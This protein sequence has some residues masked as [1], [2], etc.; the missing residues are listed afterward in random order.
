MADFKKPV[1]IV[2]AG[3]NGSGK[4]SITSKI[5]KH[6]WV[7]GCTYINPDN[8]AQNVYGDWN[9]PESVLKAVIYAE[10][11]RKKCI[12]ENKSL[13]FE[14]VFSSQEKIEFLQNAKSNGFFIRFFFVGTDHPSINAGR[15]A[16]RVMQGGHDVPISKIISRYSKSIVN[17]AAI[18]KV[19]DR[20]YIYDNSIEF[21]EPKL[22]F[23]CTTGKLLKSY[24][25][26]NEW[27][28]PI[29][30]HLHKLS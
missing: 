13:I 23:R 8:I 18:S 26:I 3:P 9:S 10:K 15:I 1:L 7:E 19:V 14:T 29:F 24:S 6:N 22:L 30:E 17:C 28:K 21:G 4:T 27:A 16:R 25:N 5:L 11:L 12:E 2:I 20:L